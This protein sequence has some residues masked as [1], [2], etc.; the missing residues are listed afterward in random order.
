[1]RLPIAVDHSQLLTMTSK[2]VD[3]I[4][5]VVTPTF[6]MA[7]PSERPL[8]W[9]KYVPQIISVVSGTRTCDLRNNKPPH[10]LFAA[11]QEQCDPFIMYRAYLAHVLHS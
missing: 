4:D 7:V 9:C 1:M 2:T 10:C 6:C 5:T 11:T 8:A 3:P